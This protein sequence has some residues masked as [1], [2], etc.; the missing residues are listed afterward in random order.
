M[1]TGELTVGEGIGRARMRLRGAMASLAL[2]MAIPIEQPTRA[3]A[4]NRVTDLMGFYV[5]WHVFGG[6]EGLQR[7]G[8]QR[9]MIYR[10]VHQ[11]EDWFGQHPDAYDFPGVEVSP[12]K[13]LQ[14]ALSDNPKLPYV[15]AGAAAHGEP[16]KLPRK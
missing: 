9:S 15:L 10:K 7:L 8:M 5:A 3:A 11:F 1:G 12:E 6:S 2:T 13:Y 4:L 16:A 14:Q